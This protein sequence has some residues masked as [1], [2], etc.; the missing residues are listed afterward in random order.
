MAIFTNDNKPPIQLSVVKRPNEVFHPEVEW[1][2]EIEKAQWAVEE[3]VKE[4]AFEVTLR[5]NDPASIQKQLEPC[6]AEIH[7]GPGH[8]STTKCGKVG[9]HEV[10]GAE[11]MG[12]MAYWRTE[13]GKESFT[14]YFDESPLNEEGE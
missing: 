7:H 14:G 10:H 12:E 2:E 8:Q 5:I 6:S 11:I 13:E 9:P 1:F 4:G 3:A